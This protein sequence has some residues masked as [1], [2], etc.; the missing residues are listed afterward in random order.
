[1]ARYS[2]AA[3]YLKDVA[4]KWYEEDYTNINNWNNLG[5]ATSFVSRF[6]RQFANAT[7]KNKW[8]SELE[9]LQQLPNQSVSEYA[10]KFKTLMSRVDPM[11]NFGQDY[12]V[13]KF[14]RELQLQLMTM[15]IGHSPNTLDAA[16]QKAKEIETGFSMA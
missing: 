15:V 16:I 11:G 8:M 7:M 10:L 14:V 4:A 2:I 9:M 3:G 12:R 5:S 1:M 6:T 13:R